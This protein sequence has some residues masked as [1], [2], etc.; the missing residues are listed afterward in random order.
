[1]VYWLVDPVNNVELEF[2]VVNSIRLTSLTELKKYTSQSDNTA[3]VIYSNPQPMTVSV[4]GIFH[5]A[6]AS[7]TE[8]MRKLLYFDKC[9]EELLLIDGHNQQVYLGYLESPSFGKSDESN[10]TLPFSFSF[11]AKGQSVGIMAEAED[12]NGLGD[13]IA[14]GVVTSDA[15]AFSDYCIVCNAITEGGNIINTQSKWL[16]PITTYRVYARAKDSAQV[17]DDLTLQIWNYGDSTEVG[18][19]TK[20]LTS[21]YKWYSMDTILSTGDALDS[22]GV[23]VFKTSATANNVSIDLIACVSTGYSGTT[24]SEI[25][26]GASS[27]YVTNGNDHDHVGGDGAQI[28]HTGLSNIGTNTHAQID[29]HIAA[30]DSVVGEVTITAGSTSVVATH[31]LGTVPSYVAKTPLDEYGIDSYINTLTTTQLT[32]NIQSPHLS[33]AVFKWEAKK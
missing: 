25:E 31:S 11:V 26:V 7:F 30:G 19:A 12:V 24:A 32:I 6:T 17:A 22:L 4:Q 20:T 27:G 1:M 23:R 9:G 29:T 2:D 18:S 14:D 21:G 33:N 10:L 15:N 5:A 16:M 8:Y 13:G 3:R 28:N